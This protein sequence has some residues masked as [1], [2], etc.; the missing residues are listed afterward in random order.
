LYFKK[1]Q[2]LSHANQIEEERQKKSNA[3]ALRNC[4]RNNKMGGGKTTRP[5]KDS[6]GKKGK[7]GKG[8]DFNQNISFKMVRG[9]TV[10]FHPPWP[11]SPWVEGTHTTQHQPTAPSK[12]R[13]FAVSAKNTLYLT[14]IV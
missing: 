4:R 8:S 3:N 1:H 12:S 2:K 13:T 14:S 11:S 6:Q 10:K 7:K 9:I 5:G